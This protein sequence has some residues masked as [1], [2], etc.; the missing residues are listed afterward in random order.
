M[1]S[2]K[3][4]SEPTEGAR[5]LWY[6]RPA[7][8]FN[9][10]SPIGNGRLGAM[11]FGS[12]GAEVLPINDDRFWAGVE[13]PKPNPNGPAELARVR[14]MIAD[15]DRHGAE[16]VIE[17]QLLTT[18]N[19]PYLP[20]ADL[21]L[22]WPETKVASYRRTLDL[23][24]A[25]VSVFQE[26][27]DGSVLKRTYFASAPD[28]VIVI[29]AE[30]TDRV[31]AGF[32]VELSAKT[33]HR[34]A[35]DGD[36]IVVIADA[37]SNVIWPGVDFRI[38]FG[39]GIFYDDV[40]PRRCA[41][42]ARVL[43]DADGGGL[44]VLVAAVTTDIQPDAVAHCRS[45]LDQAQE[46]GYTALLSRHVA[47]HSALFSR[48]SLRLGPPDNSLSDL[49]TDER[50]LQQAQGQRDPGLQALLFHFGR[51]L[52]IASSRPGCMPAN[53]MGI[54]NDLVQPPWWSNYTVNINLQMNYWPAEVCNLSECHEPLFDFLDAVSRNGADTARI[55]YG[56][57]GW[58]AH[59][60]IDG[61]LQTTPVGRLENR[62][63]DYPD[64][65]TR[66][67]MWP[68]AGPWL[69]QHLWERYR[70]DGDKTFLRE[71]AWPLMRGSAEFMLDWLVDG[72]DGSLT[73]SPSTSPENQYMSPE[74]IRGAVCTGS[75]MDLSILRL[76]FRTCLEIARELAVQDLILPRI[77]HAL[78]RLMPLR[79]GKHGQ[80]MEWDEDWDEG[81]H[82]HR[83][84]SQLFDVFPGDAIS[85]ARTPELAQA[86]RRTLELRGETGTGWGF[87]WK[88]AIW[89]RLRDAESAYRQIGYLF[90]PLS[91]LQLQFANE[92]GGIYPSLLTAC[93]PFMIESNFGYTSGVA[94]MLVQSHADDI[95]LLPALPKEW[96]EGA[97]DGLRCRG[98]I[99][100]GVSWRHGTPAQLRVRSAMAQSR[101]ICFK[102]RLVDIVLNKDE[103]ITLDWNELV[104]EYSRQ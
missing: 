59:H 69:C 94:E 26:A 3:T 58:V 90:N 88:I 80:I 15:G 28:Q 23:E 71:R 89:A 102:E 78:S 68:M 31:L 84:V 91:P 81:E 16:K 96:S 1:H 32:K 77:E 6:R 103:P 9:D 75:A 86:A 63:S 87:A 98:G 76:H 2:K 4:S 8:N 13:A 65:A 97:F 64:I 14:K 62:P 49:S 21:H 79:I 50:V 82:P 66:Y 54:W 30:A 39:E 93:P 12:N 25:L 70:Y 52:M 74:G 24:T 51:Y 67:G 17:D 7:V 33:R 35:R 104:G 48:V 11:I 27:E 42:V 53:L 95:V 36:D 44:T 38:A 43:R 40:P 83:H 47:D 101:R 18:F 60:Q 29:R 73:T 61:L 45:V 20:A 10:A 100:L 99:E 72:P 85:D 41:T 92:G 5:L 34:I 37:P 46:R 19:Q 55:H 22:A 56:M 57:R